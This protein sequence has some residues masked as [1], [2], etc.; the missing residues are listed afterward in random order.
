MDLKNRSLIK[1]QMQRFRIT[2]PEALFATCRKAQ[3]P[4]EKKVLDKPVVPC[5]NTQALEGAP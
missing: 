3:I 5:Y 4:E 2:G 1:I